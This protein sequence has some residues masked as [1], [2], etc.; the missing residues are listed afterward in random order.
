MFSLGRRD[1]LESDVK[2]EKLY[3]IED[4]KGKPLS[5][6]DVGAHNVVVCGITYMDGAE[7]LTICKSLYEMEVEFAFFATHSAGS[8]DLYWYIADKRECDMALNALVANAV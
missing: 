8:I 4:E 2:L 7:R 3:I 5:I 6:P 1:R